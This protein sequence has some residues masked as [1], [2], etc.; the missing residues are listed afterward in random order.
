LKRERKI[1]ESALNKSEENLKLFEERHSMGTQDFYDR[2]QK[3]EFGDEIE[4]M[5]WAG[6]YEALNILKDQLRALESIQIEEHSNR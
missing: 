6:E 3:D 4:F 1:L 2:F 5:K